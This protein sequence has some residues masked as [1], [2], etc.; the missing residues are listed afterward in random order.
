MKT[1]RINKML[2]C[3]DDKKFLF[4]GISVSIAVILV[5]ILGYGLGVSNQASV[6]AF[7]YIESQ[8]KES[9]EVKGDQIA[10]FYANPFDAVDAKGTKFPIAQLLGCRNWEECR[11]LCSK[12]ANFQECVAWEKSEEE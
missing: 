11:T 6:S 5:G 4:G 1:K 3:V 8:R 10:P 7:S 12:P 9:R 2:N